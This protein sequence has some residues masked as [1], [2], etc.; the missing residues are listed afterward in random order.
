MNTADAAVDDRFPGLYHAGAEDFGFGIAVNAAR[1][2]GGLE[3]LLRLAAVAGQ[4]FGADLMPAG[5]R[6]FER[7]GEVFFIR[8]GDDVKVDA[9]AGDG[10]RKV[11]C[12]FRNS[13]RRGELLAR[14]AERE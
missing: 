14:R 11:R 7:D 8:Q 5:F 1:A 12:R 4:R 2:A 3:H 10:I 9:V 13:P 6:E